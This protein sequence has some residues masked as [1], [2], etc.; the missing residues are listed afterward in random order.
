MHHS[1]ATIEKRAQLATFIERVVRPIESI[2]GLI[3]IG[4]IASGR[5]RPDSDIDLIA[6]L[7]PFDMYA[8]PA[9]AI[10]LAED[11]SF[12]SIFSES[13]DAMQVDIAR[14]DLAH[15]RDAGFAWP[16]GRKAEL[17]HGC[18]LLYT[19][20][21]SRKLWRDWPEMTW[22]KWAITSMAML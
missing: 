2:Q 14:L 1:P 3:G 17:V 8:L 4:S 6:F 21:S 16:E 9:E 15:W 5:A 19:S 13:F 11:S 18:C 7:E 20:R 12:H 22:I 10:W